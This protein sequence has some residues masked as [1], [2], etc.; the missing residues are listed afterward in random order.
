[1]A[2]KNGPLPRATL[3][4]IVAA[5]DLVEE[6]VDVPEWGR[7]IKVRGL[8]VRE[9]FEAAEAG[10][11]KPR[12]AVLMLSRAFVEPAISEE[13]AQLLLDKSGAAMMRILEAITRAN[14]GRV[15]SAGTFRET[16]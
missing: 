7:S 15:I 11:D 16:A 4:E 14:E 6:D 2:G 3:E 5:Q 8:T 1:M 9:Q 12:Q 10:D 13:Q